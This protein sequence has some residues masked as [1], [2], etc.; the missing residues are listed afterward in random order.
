MYVPKSVV[1][2]M[3]TSLRRG[4]IWCNIRPRHD[5][6]AFGQEA[7]AEKGSDL[8]F[9]T[10]ILEAEQEK[11]RRQSSVLLSS[12]DLLR[13]LN[14]TWLLLKREHACVES[15]INWYGVSKEVRKAWCRGAWEHDPGLP[16][17]Y[18]HLTFINCYCCKSLTITSLH[19]EAMLDLPKAPIFA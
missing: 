2:S 13:E 4:D 14:E 17:A 16:F 15:N 19:R 9:L 7:M 8:H 3:I 1:F 12:S 18:F 10:C 5:K 11:A 6:P